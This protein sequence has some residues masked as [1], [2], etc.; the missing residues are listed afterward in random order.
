MQILKWAG[1]DIG[2]NEGV[3]C[4]LTTAFM[5]W[6]EQCS[7]VL[8]FNSSCLSSWSDS[9]AAA[10]SSFQSEPAFVLLVQDRF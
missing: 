7:L 5:A 1:D 8:L 2:N 3:V 6:E 4:H 10:S 9:R